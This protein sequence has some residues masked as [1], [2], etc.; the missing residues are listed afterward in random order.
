MRAVQ[1]LRSWF[2]TVLPHEGVVIGLVVAYSLTDMVQL[3]PAVQFQQQ[4]FVETR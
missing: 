1:R 2:R 3:L 4:Q